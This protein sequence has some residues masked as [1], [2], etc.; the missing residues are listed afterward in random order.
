MNKFIPTILFVLFLNVNLFGQELPVHK[1]T[2]NEAPVDLGEVVVLG[3]T[4]IDKKP[5]GYLSHSVDWQILDVYKGEIKS[6]LYHWKDSEK[7]FFGSG[8]IKRRLYI[9]ANVAYL[10]TNNKVFIKTISGT[11]DIGGANPGP[12]PNPNPEP[13]PSFPDGRYKLSATVYKLANKNVP[14][15]AKNGAAEIAKSYKSIST[16]IAAGTLTKP[17]EILIEVTKTNKKALADVNIPAEKWDSFFTDLQ[18]IVYALYTDRKLVNK[19]DFKAAFDEI[20]LG[21][22]KVKVN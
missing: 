22:E 21:L 8:I 11:L 14:A 12:D 5:T 13:D 15:D 6:K 20:A 7:I 3:L 18:E 4:P 9:Y 19:D 16:R 10:Y 17:E 1:I 2:G